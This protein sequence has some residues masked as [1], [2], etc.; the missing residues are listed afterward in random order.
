MD[1]IGEVTYEQSDSFYLIAAGTPALIEALKVSVSSGELSIDL[2][3]KRQFSGDKKKLFIRLGSPQLQLID[4]NSVGSFHLI[5]TFKGDRLTINNNGVG[6]I[7]IDDCHVGTFEL[8]AKGVGSIEV[9][10]TS[11]NAF[12]KSE[13]VGN[14]DASDFKCGNIKVESK[15]AGAISVYAQKSLDISIAGIGN[16]SYYGN[17]S[18]VK[19]NIS[20]LGNARKM[21]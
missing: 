17:P 11:D 6:Q 12:M 15:G 20:G 19:T 2:S 13:G 10:G 9:K 4:F 7:I 16:V 21:N 18:D 14:I 1:I 5:N 3:N 8:M